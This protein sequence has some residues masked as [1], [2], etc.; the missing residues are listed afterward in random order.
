VK[1]V[2]SLVSTRRAFVARS[3]AVAAGVACGALLKV[4]GA[5]AGRPPAV[6]DDFPRSV[7]L[8]RA[9]FENWARDIVVESL[10]TCAPRA[11]EEIAD[12]ATWAARHGYTVRPRGRMHNFSPLSVSAHTPDDA[13]VLMVDTTRHLTGMKLLSRD[14]GAVR[15]QAGAQ[16]EDLL[17]FLERNGLGLAAFPAPG[18]L[19]IGGVLAI[20]GHGTG[21]PAPGKRA[22]EGHT[23]GSVS[24]LVL[25][26]TAVVWSPRRRRYVLRTFDRDDPE[27]GGLLAHVGRAFI[28]EATLRAGPSQRMR[29]VSKVDVPLSALFPADNSRGARSFGNDVD[30]STGVEVI[31]FPFTDRPWLKLWTIA[32]E[33]PAGARAVTGPYNYPFADTLSDES[34]KQIAAAVIADGST[35]PEVGRDFYELSAT[36]LRDTRSWDIWGPNMDVLLYTR[37]STLRVTANG[38]AVHCR[39]RDVQR[40]SGDFIRAYQSVVRRYARRGQ[41]PMN[42]PV[43]IRVTTLDHPRDAG[44]S[45]AQPVLLSPL[46]PNPR[47][48]EF[49]CAVWLDILTFPGTPLANQAFREIEQWV[50]RRYRPPYAFV[51]PEW[52]K[53][54]AYTNRAA[55]ADPVMLSRTIPNLFG[56][57]RRDGG[58][59]NAAVGALNRLDPHHVFTAPL[60][61]RLM[62]LRR[63]AGYVGSS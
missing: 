15:V 10:W 40:V 50:F 4:D 21:L 26:L 46:A 27:I 35:T 38:Y 17:A 61:R 19:T 16:M 24:N 52:S 39:R 8:Y 41:Y 11:P 32:P 47:F 33:R 6:F 51:R 23:Y 13:R 28:T 54:W 62:R 36:G 9:G 63:P 22:A 12:I 25:S 45:G 14:P 60:V 55:W 56:A 30:R 29:C 57:G 1:A 34:Q 58:A 43:E 37:A 44:V 42:M 48:P 49:D 5:A 18:D 2:Q 20:A 59:W 31:L 7:E 3:S 53:G